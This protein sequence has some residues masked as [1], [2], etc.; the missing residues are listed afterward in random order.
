M[1]M[2]N[3][4]KTYQRH[5]SGLLLCA[6]LSY[7]P[8]GGHRTLSHHRRPRLSQHPSGH[9]RTQVAIVEVIVVPKIEH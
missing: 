8:C 2:A 9:H 1:C 5:V 4:K 3:N 7:H 6:R